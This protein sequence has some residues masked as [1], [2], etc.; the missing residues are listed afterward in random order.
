V[1]VRINNNKMVLANNCFSLKLLLSQLN[2]SLHK[3]RAIIARKQTL[4]TVLT[5]K[6]A[7]LTRAKCILPAPV[8]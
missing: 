7:Q 2:I 5:I 6:V 3:S 4:K 1:E 8:K